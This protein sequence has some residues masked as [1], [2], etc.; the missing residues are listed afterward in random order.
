MRRV[1]FAGTLNPMHRTRTAMLLLAI[2]LSCSPD[3]PAQEAATAPELLRW[4]KGGDKPA[5]TVSSGLL[6]AS[7][8]ETAVPLM[9]GPWFEE[10]SDLSIEIIGGEPFRVADHRGRIILLDFWASWCTPCRKELPALQTLQEEEGESGLDVVTVNVDEPDQVAVAMISDLGLNLPVG[11]FSDRLA[12]LM[13][14]R[15]LPSALLLDGEG[16]IRR[17]WS[18]YGEGLVEVFRGEIQ[19]LLTGDPGGSPIMLGAGTEQGDRYGVRWSRDLS[20]PVTGLAVVANPEGEPVIVVT[21]GRELVSLRKDG[22][23]VGRLNAPSGMVSLVA[24]DLNTDGV[25]DLIGYRRGSRK[26]ATYDF[27]SRTATTWDAPV[28]LFSIMADPHEGRPPELIAGALDRF[29]RLSPDGTVLGT[30]SSG[31]AAGAWS[32]LTGPGLAGFGVGSNQTVAGVAGRFGESGA[33]QIALATR[34][35]NLMILEAVTGSLQYRASWSGITALAAWDLD[36]DG[37]DEVVVASGDRV[38]VLELK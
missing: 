26:V 4:F 16:R 17:H 23:I 31:P 11:R 30:E 29:Y 15:T 2:C 8:H 12:G 25:A 14:S 13:N 3:L 22:K 7:K 34:D 21:A 37:M 6:S 38:T 32:L 10:A 28:G 19:K 33:G 20:R 36:S 35:G 27:V 9:A 1:G 5:W 18:G 24:A